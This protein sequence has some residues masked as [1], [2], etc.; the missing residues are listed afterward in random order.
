MKRILI[1][2]TWRTGSSFLGDLISSSPGVFYSFEPLHYIDEQQRVL[3]DANI[4]LSVQLLRSVFRCRFTQDYLN[5][6]NGIGNTSQTFMTKNRRVWQAC[7]RNRS[8]CTQPEFVHRIC[9]HFSTHLVKVVRMRLGLTRLVFDQLPD[10]MTKIVFLVRDPRGVMASRAN[11]T[12]CQQSSCNNATVLCDDTYQDLQTYAE[13]KAKYPDNYYF[14]KFEDLSQN[15]EEETEKL[16]QFLGL[17]VNSPIKLFLTTHTNGQSNT[18]STDPY[19]TQRRSK[20]VAEKW[21]Q[22]LSSTEIS[23]ISE[24]C[25]PLLKT[26][27]YEPNVIIANWNVIRLLIEH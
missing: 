7:A 1:V 2:S 25:K 24:S 26:L 18:N 17:K 11:L 14:L 13:F 15:M 10:T 9:N 16:F 23:S 22:I 5:H 19:S 6:I 8:L 27:H 4:R 21:R 3:S 12:W 20:D